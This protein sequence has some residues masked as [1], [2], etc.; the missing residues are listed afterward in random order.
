[1]IKTV[2][3]VVMEILVILAKW[4]ME[5]LKKLEMDVSVLLLVLLKIKIEQ[6]VCVKMGTIL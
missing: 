6:N 3:S 2:K 4:C 5:V 1:M